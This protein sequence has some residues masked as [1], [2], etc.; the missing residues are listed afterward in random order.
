MS[1][2]IHVTFIKFKYRVKD[3][4]FPLKFYMVKDAKGR[5]VQAKWKTN[6]RTNEATLDLSGKIES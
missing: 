2:N 5:H 1:F 3:L 6:H 4:T